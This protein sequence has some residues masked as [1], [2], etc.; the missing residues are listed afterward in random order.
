MS[1]FVVE[2]KRNDKYRIEV[3][4]GQEDLDTSQY[5][6]VMGIWVCDDLLEATMMVAELY[7]M[8]SANEQS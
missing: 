6:H 8:R 1:V 2:H 7:K 3:V 5:D 4:S